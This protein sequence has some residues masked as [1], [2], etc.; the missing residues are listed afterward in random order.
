MDAPG[1]QVDTRDFIAIP[2]A[3][4]DPVKPPAFDVI[5]YDNFVKGLL[6][7]NGETLNALHVALGVAGEAGELADA[8]KK[9]YIYNKPRDLANI[10]E[11][12]GDLEFYLQAVRLHYG[13]SREYILQRNADKL[14]K[15]YVSLHYSDAAAIERADKSS[16]SA[17]KD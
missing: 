11:E 10:I 5:R 3:P 2:Y 9:E 17:Q 7:P 12:L 4:N 14:S 15:R 8:I 1:F 16:D 6:K 13:F